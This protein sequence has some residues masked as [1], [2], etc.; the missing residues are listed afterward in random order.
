M[1]TFGLIRGMQ[2]SRARRG[3]GR[4]PTELHSISL[5][6]VR[7]TLQ[8]I[9]SIKLEE[10][11]KQ[12]LAFEAHA[13]VLEKAA[14]CRDDLRKVE[15]LLD[16][17]R[18]WRGSGAV[19]ST[20]FIG[21][22]LDLSSLD[23]WL[24]Q[25]HKDPGFS[26]DVVKDWADSLEAH[27]RHSMTRFEFAKLFGGLFNEWLSSGD[28]VLE[29]ES[30][31]RATPS[32]EFVEVG[33]KE[34]F[35]Q[36]ERLKSIIFEPKTIDTD[37]LFAY[38]AD[39]FSDGSSL[40]VLESMRSGMRDFGEDLRS[41]VITAD[42]MKWVIKSLLAAGLML[43][44][45]RNTLREFTQNPTVLDELATVMTMRLGSLEAWSWPEHGCQIDMRR[46]LNGKYRAFTDPDLLD[47]LF[48]QYIGIMWQ[49]KFKQDCVDIFSSKAWKQEFPPLSREELRDRQKCFAESPS[50]SIHSHRQTL[51]RDHFLV[52]QLSS[53]VDSTPSY[54]DWGNPDKTQ[55]PASHVKQ[56]L[57]H[58]VA[59]ECYLNSTLHK[60]HTV[61]CTDLEWFGPSLAFDT[62]LTCLDFF[63]VSKTWLKF[64]KSFLQVP[65]TFKDDKPGE[66]P[67]IRQCGTPISYALS[68]FFGEVVLFG[69]DFAIN[70][71]AEGLFLY[72]IHD[73]IWFWDSNSANTAVLTGLKFNDSKTG[74]ACVGGDLAPEL[75]SGEIRWGFLRF[76]SDQSRFVI[77]QAE[78]DKHIVELRRQLAATKSVF[79]FINAY[80]RNVYFD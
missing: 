18:S 40:E 73:D 48:L 11:E 4:V 69:L 62:I 2:S 23:L 59:T 12:R 52:G 55:L 14:A 79:G 28:S 8:F 15:L 19:S 63:G 16:A 64:F 70:Q 25:A 80:N 5:R 56:E 44:E 45:K 74:S 6:L 22:K 30:S 75:P 29:Q 20:T 65:L 26:S 17:V 37:G 46:H 68:A 51:R 9:T 21:G 24:L 31:P 34:M 43:E 38:L 10:L 35:E 3:R 32:E 27:I 50:E 71:R 13:S 42:D 78:V 77:D 67:R 53:H 1:S 72:R 7:E 61:V 33:R 36:Q 58:T 47:A 60:T 39:L 41:R 54:D 76:E 66:A 49:T 57:L